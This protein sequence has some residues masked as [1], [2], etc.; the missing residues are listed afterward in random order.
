MSLGSAGFDI[1]FFV[2]QQLCLSSR[3]ACRTAV[4]GGALAAFRS[5]AR[6]RHE[7]AERSRKRPTTVVVVQH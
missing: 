1:F 2:G 3:T 7:E 4:V 6:V 5:G